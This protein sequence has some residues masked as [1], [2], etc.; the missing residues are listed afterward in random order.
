MDNFDPLVIHVKAMCKN[1]SR[2]YVGAVLRPYAWII[3]ES[4]KKGAQVSDIYDAMKQAGHQLVADGKMKSDTLDI[5]ARDFI[6]R[7]LVVDIM[8]DAFKSK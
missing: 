2:E 8:K 7:E 1:M 5:V 4:E 3:E 6:P